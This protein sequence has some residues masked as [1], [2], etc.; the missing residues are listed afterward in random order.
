MLSWM[1][2]SKLSK[3]HWSYCR[4][5]TIPFA[6]TRA[7]PLL[8]YL[9]ICELRYF[10]NATSGTTWDLSAEI[11]MS[12]CVCIILSNWPNPSKPSGND[13]GRANVVSI[14]KKYI[15]WVKTPQTDLIHHHWRTGKSF[16]RKACHE[17][18]AASIVRRVLNRAITAW[19]GTQTGLISA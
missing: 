11:M 19:V 8:G 17:K 18:W 3:F 15:V 16:L 10:L 4:H 13:D 9:S 5:I 2:F 1:V 6:K 14:Y 12:L 7:H